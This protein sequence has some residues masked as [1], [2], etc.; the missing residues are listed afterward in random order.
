VANY[1]THLAGGIVVGVFGAL[2]SWYLDMI[3][4]FGIPVV[5]L[6]GIVGGIAPDIDHDNSRPI[7]IIFN[8]AT[9][10]I[11]TLLLWR[12][13]SL[14]RQ[15]DV[16]SCIWIFVALAI[17][18]PICWIFKKLT[19]HRG[20]F[21]SVPAAL[22]FGLTIY[23]LM[24]QRTDQIDLQ[25][26]LGITGMMGYFIHLVLDEA[27]SVD[28]NNKRIKRSFGTAMSLYKKNKVVNVFSYVVLF[29]LCMIS[30]HDYR[31]HRPEVLFDRHILGEKAPPQKRPIP[32]FLQ[33]RTIRKR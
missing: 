1:P 26:S 18:F 33:D 32:R 3:S 31:G 9:V 2:A 22:I 27:Y 20:I 24:G 16:A 8:W 15:W 25:I 14:T 21:H 23:I 4:P 5:A 6:S 30:Y 13:D 11:P 28:F 7:R 12:F 17:Y 29:V 10:I 19:V